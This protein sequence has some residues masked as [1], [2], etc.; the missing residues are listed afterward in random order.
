MPYGVYAVEYEKKLRT[1]NFGNKPANLDAFLS[2]KRGRTAIFCEMKM[3]EWLNNPSNVS[4]S[5]FLEESYFAE[6]SDFIEK[7]KHGAKV[8]IQW[9]KMIKDCSFKRY[10]AWQ[11]FKH[12]LAIYNYTSFTTQKSVNILDNS[13]AGVYEKV[14]L[15]N[16]VNEFPSI[17]IKDVKTKCDYEVMLNEEREEAK[18][19]IQTFN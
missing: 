19:F 3:F 16:V 18:R 11:M 1:V 4:N 10:D 13:F 6:E 2:D 5:Y 8:F 9:A 7:A 15:A 14:T 17:H 12:T